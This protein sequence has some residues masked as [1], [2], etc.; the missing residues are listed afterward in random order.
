MI[1]TYF[2]QFYSSS[3]RLEQTHFFPGAFDLSGSKGINTL[4]ISLPV[5]DVWQKALKIK[6]CLKSYLTENN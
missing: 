3:D 1:D 6:Y 5:L 2:F 4:I